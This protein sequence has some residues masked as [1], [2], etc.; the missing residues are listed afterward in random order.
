MLP[1]SN[2]G[3][4]VSPL[5][6]PIFIPPVS[7]AELLTSLQTSSYMNFL[8]VALGDCVFGGH[9]S[10]KWLQEEVGVLRVHAVAAF[11][12]SGLSEM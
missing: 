10:A 1:R 4:T 5:Y 11:V 12:F 7:P 2:G 9:E 6:F 3:E 8:S